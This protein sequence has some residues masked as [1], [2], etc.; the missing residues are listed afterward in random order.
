[1]MT[2]HVEAPGESQ[3]TAMLQAE[4]IV[5][6]AVQTAIPGGFNLIVRALDAAP[7][8]WQAVLWWEPSKWDRRTGW[9]RI[10]PG[11]EP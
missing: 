3:A 2:V 4:Q 1:M 9:P 10:S 5:R 11:R 6:G 8:D 7:P